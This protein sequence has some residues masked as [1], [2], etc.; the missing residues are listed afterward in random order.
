MD[1][2]SEVGFDVWKDSCSIDSVFFFLISILLRLEYVDLL[3]S[4]FVMH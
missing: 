4:S 1:L 2:A 3:S